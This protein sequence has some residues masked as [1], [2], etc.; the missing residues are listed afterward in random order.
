MTELLGDNKFL[1]GSHPTEYDAAVFGHL[2]T[3]LWGVP[4]S[5]LEATIK[6]KFDVYHIQIFL[7]I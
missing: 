7:Q 1:L 2:S 3:A 4:G 6:S 5:E